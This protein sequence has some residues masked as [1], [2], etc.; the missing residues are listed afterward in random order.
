MRFAQWLIN[1][2][3]N[4]S[5]RLRQQPRGRRG[6][7]RISEASGDE[8]KPELPSAKLLLLRSWLSLAFKVC[9]T[10]TVKRTL[11]LMDAGGRKGDET[12]P[13]LPPGCTS[14]SRTTS[15]ATRKPERETREETPR[16]AQCDSLSINATVAFMSCLSDLNV[17][18][19]SRRDSN[20]FKSVT[21]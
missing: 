17:P 2:A 10:T 1:S 18:E 19:P 11:T 6:D 16:R 3:S 21:Y 7:P 12:F 13:F 5:R 15:H 20:R 4:V 14:T 9:T 8:Q